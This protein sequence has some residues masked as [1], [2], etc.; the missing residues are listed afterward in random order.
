ML[1]LEVDTFEANYSSSEIFR[2]LPLISTELMI[3]PMPTCEGGASVAIM[4]RT[5][6]QP[7]PIVVSKRRNLSQTKPTEDVINHYNA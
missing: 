5:T 6:P 1:S 4:E 7:F 2:K 3:N